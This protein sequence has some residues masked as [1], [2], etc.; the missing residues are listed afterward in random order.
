MNTITKVLILG[1]IGFA[2]GQN[3]PI[4]TATTS[5]SV[6]VVRNLPSP[7]SSV[8]IL[9]P[10]L[11]DQGDQDSSFSVIDILFRGDRVWM[12]TSVGVYYSPDYGETWILLDASSGL[13]RGGVSGLAVSESQLW[14]ATSHETLDVSI[15]GSGLAY[16]LD[17]G[18]HWEWLP[19]PTDSVADDT[20][21]YFGHSIPA[22][23]LT[24]TIFNVTYDIALT[25]SLVFIASWAGGLRKSM[26]M[27]YSW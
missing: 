1:S 25:D 10:K 2:L 18:N 17:N 7:F 13:G 26:N 23:P 15:A 12:G 5:S 16:T 8:G 20:V 19:Q 6:L 11:L 4:P 21:I 24:S 22:L 27:G 14:A 3:V 9:V